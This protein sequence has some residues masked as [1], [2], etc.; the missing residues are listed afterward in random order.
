MSAWL[1]VE[2]IVARSC[3]TL[4]DPVDCSPPGPSVQD[5]P[6]EN[7]GGGCRLLLQGIFPTQGQPRFPASQADSFL[8]EPPGKPLG[9]Y[10]YCPKNVIDHYSL[11]SANLSDFL[12]LHLIKSFIVV[13]L[14]HNNVQIVQR[15]INLKWTYF[16]SSPQTP[17]SPWQLTFVQ[18][19]LLIKLCSHIFSSPP[20]NKV[21]FFSSLLLME[22]SFF[23]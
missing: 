13:L 8:S 20:P 7:T 11:Y 2:V 22:K 12:L 15:F 10:G 3:P 5:S 6:G 9:M 1:E 18:L 14:T 19:L 4:W 17:P 23:L 21:C 16:F